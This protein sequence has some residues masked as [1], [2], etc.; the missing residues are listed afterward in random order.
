[1]KRGAYVALLRGVNVGGRNR[2]PMLTL[3][4]IFAQAGCANVETFIQSGNVVFEADG[5]IA[6]ALPTAAPLAIERLAGFV[7]PVVVRSALAMRRIVE[8]NPF[9]RGAEA[10]QLYVMCLANIPTAA[11]VAALDKMRSHPD[12]FEV[13]GADIY[14]RL[15]NG[16]ARTKLTNSWF[17][18]A[19]ETVGTARNWRT[20]SRLEELVRAR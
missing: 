20:T 13:R 6:A 14:L 11:A 15:I 5:A 10:D 16:M 3:K 12:E 1:M 9:P 17:D 19:L 18:R 7:A 2:L 4:R 8:G